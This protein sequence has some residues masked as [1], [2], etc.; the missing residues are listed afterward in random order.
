MIINI[1]KVQAFIRCLDIPGYP[2]DFYISKARA[3][4]IKSTDRG[5]STTC[6]FVEGNYFESTDVCFRWETQSDYCS[7]VKKTSPY[8]K[9]TRLVDFIDMVILDFLMSTFIWCT[10]VLWRL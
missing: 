7:S 9:G 6:W 5:I 2:L 3:I 8:N 10:C 1:I 4:I